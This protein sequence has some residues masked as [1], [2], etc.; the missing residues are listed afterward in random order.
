MFCVT[1]HFFLPG[2]TSVDMYSNQRNNKFYVGED[3]TITAQYSNPFVV[4]YPTWQFNGSSNNI[5]TKLRKYAGTRSENNKDLLII[6]DCCELDAGEYSVVANCTPNIEIC[7]EKL[8]I[9]VIKG[10]ISTFISIMRIQ[11]VLY[12]TPLKCLFNKIRQF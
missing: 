10:K 8:K 5:D 11:L 9:E 6:R 2:I 4:L 1:I 12:C 7:S 3:V